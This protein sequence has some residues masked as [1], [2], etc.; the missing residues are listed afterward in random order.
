M[1]QAKCMHDFLFLFFLKSCGREKTFAGPRDFLV[2]E[3]SA[4]KQCQYT[5]VKRNAACLHDTKEKKVH[6]QVFAE[7]IPESM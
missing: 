2:T 5:I 1:F 6:T 4:L 3:F 7:L